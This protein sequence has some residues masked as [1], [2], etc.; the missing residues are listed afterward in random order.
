[1]QYQN[2][3]LLDEIE[4][5]TGRDGGQRYIAQS[6]RS[7]DARRL[8][9]VFCD[10]GCPC[11]IY[12][13]TGSGKSYLAST[14]YGKK[15]TLYTYDCAP[16]G[17]EVIEKELLGEG[18]DDIAAFGHLR[19][20]NKAYRQAVALG[21]KGQSLKNAQ[22]AGIVPVGL[23]EHSVE[24]F[25]GADKL[26]EEFIS[27]FEPYQVQMYSLGERAEDLKSFIDYYL[28]SANKKYSRRR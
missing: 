15:G 12:G 13:P 5:M 8:A 16:V 18:V 1:M 19:C 6:S 7:R 21:F 20:D 10:A 27:E 14:I 23:S 3:K 9:G 22:K 28:G 11:Y 25:K 26:S 17:E 24:E 2:K 4:L